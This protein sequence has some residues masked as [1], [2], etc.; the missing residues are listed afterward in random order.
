MSDKRRS[1]EATQLLS[2][3]PTEVLASLAKIKQ[4]ED[5]YGALRTVLEALLRA[6]QQQIIDG[7]GSVISQDTMI[8]GAVHS[9]FYRGRVSLT[10][11]LN[12]LI[13]N[14]PDFLEKR[15]EGK[16]KGKLK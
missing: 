13:K 8:N 14:A 5:L 9:A 7:A 6:N 15:A 2:N 11:L 3:M 1:A 12:S 4:N 16:T 10:V